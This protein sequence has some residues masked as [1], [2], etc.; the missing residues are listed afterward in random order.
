MIMRILSWPT[1]ID[2]QAKEGVIH[3]AGPRNFGDL[4]NDRP[5]LF[6][7]DKSQRPDPGLNFFFYLRTRSEDSLTSHLAPYKVETQI[8][9]NASRIGFGWLL[10]CCPKA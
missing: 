9:T 4:N 1:H 7:V 5:I 3:R 6:Q 2:D 10:G 8:R